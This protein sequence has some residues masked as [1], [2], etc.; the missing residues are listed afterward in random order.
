[1]DRDTFTLISCSI[2]YNKAGYNRVYVYKYSPQKNEIN[3][4]YAGA[5]FETIYEEEPDKSKFLGTEYVIW[6]LGQICPLINATLKR[7][8]Y[9][10][11]WRDNNFSSKPVY[12][13]KFDNI[14]KH[15][16]KEKMKFIKQYANFNINPYVTS[17]E[18]LQLVRKKKYNKI[19]LISNVST[20]LGGKNFIEN[21]RKIIGNDA[22]CLFLALIILIILNGLKIIKMLYFLMSLNF[23]RNIF[24]ALE[25]IIIVLMI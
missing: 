22:I 8:E 15:F 1:M 18:A 11:I 9:C 23:K 6:D 20:D 25:I 10:I 2:Y 3:F 4:S 7:N 24:N 12:N 17:E 16:L 21:A 13:N 14:F 5:N 19:I